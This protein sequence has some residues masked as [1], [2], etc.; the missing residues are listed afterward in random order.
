V[1]LWYR[2]PHVCW[3][4]NEAESIARTAFRCCFCCILRRPVVWPLVRWR[5]RWRRHVCSRFKSRCWCAIGR[6]PNG[7]LR[8]YHAV[9]QCFSPDAYPDRTESTLMTGSPSFGPENKLPVRAAQIILVSSAMFRVVFD[10]PGANELIQA[11]STGQAVAIVANS[12]RKQPAQVLTP[13]KAECVCQGG[14]VESAQAG[15]ARQA[16]ASHQKAEFC[17]LYYHPA[18][19]WPSCIRWSSAMTST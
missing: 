1:V 3:S 16:L 6:S 7:N 13:A 15:D 2:G 17:D 14:A 10:G 19:T 9:Q 18:S 5:A 8:L 11:E 4:A 12:F